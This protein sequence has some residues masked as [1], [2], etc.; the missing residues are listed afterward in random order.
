MMDSQ[1][2]ALAPT[3]QADRAAPEDVGLDNFGQPLFEP[4]RNSS[5]SGLSWEASGSR[6]GTRL[7]GSCRVQTWQLYRRYYSITACV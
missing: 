3:G 6:S 1:P 5:Q 2:K 7:V 4:G